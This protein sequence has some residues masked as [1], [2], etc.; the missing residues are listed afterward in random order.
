MPAYVSPMVFSQSMIYATPTLPSGETLR[1]YTDSG[2]G[3]FIFSSVAER[4][5]LLTQTATET[6]GNRTVPFPRFR[7]GFMIV[8]SWPYGIRR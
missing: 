5:G 6:D 7:D 3:T 2:G 1:F 4:L 8:S